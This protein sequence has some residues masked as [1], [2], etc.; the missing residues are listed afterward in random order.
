MLASDPPKSF[1]GNATIEITCSMNVNCWVN[2]WET[3]F[4]IPGQTDRATVVLTRRGD[5]LACTC[6]GTV[7]EPFKSNSEGIHDGGTLRMYASAAKHENGWMQIES[8]RIT[9][10][11]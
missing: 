7:V 1:H 10:G 8:I 5:T 4:K 11:E 2:I 9:E 6:N 3:L